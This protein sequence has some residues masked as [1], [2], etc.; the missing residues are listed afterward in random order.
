ME[1]INTST[2]KVNWQSKRLMLNEKELASVLGVS[3]YRVRQMRL[4]QN[5]PCITYKDQHQIYYY[6]PVVDEYFRARSKPYSTEA[7]E[8]TVTEN[9]STTDIK[10]SLPDLQEPAHSKQC[11]YKTMEPV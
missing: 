6:M 2:S 10:L 4:N 9:V 3:E 7:E 5:L 1:N 8:A 11:Q